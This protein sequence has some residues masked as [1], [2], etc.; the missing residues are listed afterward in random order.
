[1]PKAIT[2]TGSMGKDGMKSIELD[3]IKQ[4]VLLDVRE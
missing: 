3:N 2:Q 1:M 4:E